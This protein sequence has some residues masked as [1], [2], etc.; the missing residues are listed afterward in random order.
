MGMHRCEALNLA[1]SSAV[2]VYNFAKATPGLERLAER[3]PRAMS[4][5]TV[6]SRFELRKLSAPFGTSAP[7]WILQLCAETETIVLVR[8]CPFCGVEL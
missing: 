7:R 6:S 1:E 3:L 2:G 8:F 4:L 5:T